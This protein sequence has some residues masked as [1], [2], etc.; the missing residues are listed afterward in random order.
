MQVKIMFELEPA[1]FDTEG[2]SVAPITCS[3]DDATWSMPLPTI[4][5]AEA[6]SVIVEFTSTS[7]Q[8]QYFTF[9]NSINTVSLEES[10]FAKF[11]SEVCS[12]LTEIKLEFSLTQQLQG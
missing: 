4:N 5:S 2:F 3:T 8:S 11:T 9:T 6:D 10:T 7:E 12:S 1:T